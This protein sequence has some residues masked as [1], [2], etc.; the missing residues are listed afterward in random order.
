MTLTLGRDCARLSTGLQFVASDGAITGAALRRCL[1]RVAAGGL[2]PCSRT[3]SASRRPIGPV[4]HRPAAR[5][6]RRRR[7]PS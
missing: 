6:Q 5:D 4:A 2:N 1:G 3:V 7:Q